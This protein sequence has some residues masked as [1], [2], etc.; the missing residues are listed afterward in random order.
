MRRRSAVESRR[1]SSPR[2]EIVPPSGVARSLDALHRRRLARAVGPDQAEDFALVDVEGD[3][4]DGDGAAVA[5]GKRADRDDGRWHGTDVTSAPPISQSAA[6]RDVCGS[7][8][9]I[10]RTFRPPSCPSNQP[11]CP[12]RPSS[13]ESDSLSAHLPVGPRRVAWSRAGVAGPARHRCRAPASPLRRPPLA[14]ARRDLGGAEH[15]RA[16]FPRPR[17]SPRLC[18]VG[19]RRLPLGPSDSRSSSAA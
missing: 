18:T 14:L 5:L 2:T 11:P 3:V 17:A 10:I 6:G 12:P 16:R 9:L 13:M 7:G 15:R 19:A 8:M 4:R 1:G